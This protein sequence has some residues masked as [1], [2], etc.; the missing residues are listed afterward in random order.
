M[1]AEPCRALRIGIGDGFEDGFESI[2]L[3]VELLNGKEAETLLGNAIEPLVAGG[4]FAAMLP[5]V[6]RGA[7]ALKALGS[8]FPFGH[9]RVVNVCCFFGMAQFLTSRFVGHR[10]FYH[11]HTRHPHLIELHLGEMQVSGAVIAVEQ[12]NILTLHALLKLL[13][14]EVLLLLQLFYEKLV[15]LAVHV[16]EGCLTAGIRHLPQTAA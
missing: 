6:G 5:V 7:C 9:N 12:N 16:D 10:I 1:G 2:L 15:V 8:D 11:P 4:D 13:Y 14:G 3:A